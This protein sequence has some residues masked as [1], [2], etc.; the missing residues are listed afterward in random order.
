MESIELVYYCFIINTYV[1]FMDSGE[2]I[3]KEEKENL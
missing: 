3:G 2:V 1:T